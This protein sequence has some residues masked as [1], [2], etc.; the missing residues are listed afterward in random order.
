ML[1]ASID[2][3]TKI[4]HY[5]LKHLQKLKKQI[6]IDIAVITQLYLQLCITYQL[7]VL[8]IS[9]LAIVKLETI[10]RETI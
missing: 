9:D 4:I 6:C 8:A 2:F 7:Q 5:F 3:N 10:I 1:W